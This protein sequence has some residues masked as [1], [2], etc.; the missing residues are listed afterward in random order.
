MD[1]S[2]KRILAYIVDIAIVTIFVTLIANIDVINPYREEYDQSYN[3]YIEVNTSYQEK[4]ISYEEYRD[5]MVDINYSLNKNNIVSGALTV[6]GLLI[7]F[8]VATYFWHGQTMGKK[9]MNLQ[10]VAYKKDKNLNLGNYLL[11]TIL[12]NNLVFRIL[13]LG[14]TFFLNKNAYY[15]YSSI[16]SV[17]ESIIESVIL[18]MVVL[19]TD[20]RGLHDMI[21]NTMVIDLKNAEQENII[22][23]VKVIEKKKNTED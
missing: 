3:D 22:E 18:L 17:I 2:L 4:E 23:D 12:L 16:I 19:K 13:I 8:G 7:Y 10:I 21:A 15:N 6:V 20:H 5:K 9:L 11:R 14:G 1:I